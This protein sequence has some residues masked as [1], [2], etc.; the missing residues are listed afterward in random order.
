[1]SLHGKKDRKRWHDDKILVHLIEFGPNS[2]PHVVVRAWAS[3]KTIPWTCFPLANES[4]WKY[5][6]LINGFFSFHEPMG[7]EDDYII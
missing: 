4:L 1:M 7:I 5:L 3:F 2:N 6:F